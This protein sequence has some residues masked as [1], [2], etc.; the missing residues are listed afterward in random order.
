MQ[1]SKLTGLNIILTGGAGFIG[2]N[3]AARLAS[4]DARVTVIDNLLTGT[5]DNISGLVK[6]G[7]I[8]F[9]E[10]DIRDAKVCAK[11]MQ[12]ADVVLHQAALGSVP[13]SIAEPLNTHSINIE[14][15][16]N[17]LEQTRLAGITRF[18]YASSSSVYGNDL[19]SPKTELNT[20]VPLSP[21]ALTKSV[22]EQYAHLYA[23]VYGMEIIGLRYFNVF[24]P[25]QQPGGPY[26][27]VIPLFIT[28]MLAGKTPV[29]FGDG[30]TTR[31]FTYVDNVVQANLAAL[32]IDK[33]PENVLPVFNIACGATTSLL[34][35]YQLIAAATGFEQQPV[36]M[37]ERK[38][39]IRQSFASVDAA[40]NYL[41]Y[42]PEVDL[43]NGIEKTVAW[44]RANPQL[45]K[46]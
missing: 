27:A 45:I 22:N 37:P 28:Q 21:Y 15:F 13:R 20:G 39:D 32:C 36:F 6:N 19:S 44:F 8:K 29:I 41:G 3:L 5:Y 2:S 26:A 31:D 35:L 18:I 23:R 4:Y 42:Q 24:G 38:G 10:A 17:V 7:K 12:G 40:A 1:L 46:L 30:A 16:V 14:G 43:R 33:L 9:V 25:N 34:E 11:F